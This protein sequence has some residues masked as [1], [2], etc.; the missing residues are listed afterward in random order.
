MG[1]PGGVRRLIETALPLERIGAAAVRESQGRVQPLHPW[2]SRKP[3]PAV[4]AVLLASLLADPGSGDRPALLER[5]AEAAEAAPGGEGIAAARRLL[6]G[7][8]PLP[9]VVDPFCGS[10]A[11]PAEAQRLG[12]PV[13]A[14]DLNPVAVLMTRALLEVPGRFAERRP[15]HPGAPFVAQGR[16]DG[17]IADILHYGQR[18]RAEAARRIGALYPTDAAGRPVIAW[19]WARTAPCPN[20]A[21]RQAMPLLHSFTLGAREGHEAWLVPGAGGWR[22]EGVPGVAPPAEGT[23]T[24]RTVRC[25]HCGQVTPLPV[26]R[27]R[28]REAG[29][30]LTLLCRVAQQ[31][32]R[33]GYTEAVPGEEAAALAA[34]S[35]WAPE[36]RLPEAALGFGTAN[37]GF[38]LHRDLYAPRQLAALTTFADAV[39][40]VREAVEADARRAGLPAGAALRDGGDGAVAHAEA[41]TLYLALALDRAAA[42]WCTFARWHRTRENIEHPFATPGLPMPWDFAE[43]NPFSE[44]TGNW[45]D[46]VEAVA[47]ALAAAPAAEGPVPPARCVQADAAEAPAVPGP[48]LVCTD[49]PYFDMVPFAD[50]SDLFYIWLRPTAGRIY[51]DLFRT[52]LTPKEGE[53]VADARRF[54]G[55][56]PARAH[57]LRGMT[58]AFQRLAAQAGPDHPLTIFYAFREDAAAGAPRGW[59]VVLE[60]LVAAGLQV[61]GTWPLRT[62]H[63]QRLRSRASN[64]LATSIV[65][66]C[67]PRPADAGSISRREFAAALRRQLPTALQ[68]L[69]DGGVAP[70]DLA[71][72]AIGPGM[73]IFTRHAAVQGDEGP[74]TMGAALALIGE[75]LAAHLAADTAELDAGTR[76]CLT[77][78]EW[79][80]FAAGAYG[81]AEV[82]AR[83]RDVS[84]EA[85][86]RDGA[87]VAEGGRVRLIRAGDYARRVGDRGRILWSALQL[88][89]AGLA[90]GGEEAA[91]EAMRACGA[92]EPDLRVLAHRLYAICEQHRE[93]ESAALYD[94][95]AEALPAVA[96]RARRATGQRLPGL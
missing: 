67:R 38:R 22:L 70:A 83:A 11:I 39:A 19:L 89:A 61:V 64:T 21:C 88:V 37:Y 27:E 91:A 85:L 63:P 30:G 66:V 40:A 34:T 59:E 87:L 49:P 55:T 5:V 71:Q 75:T 51:P 90:R 58:A 54:G 25:L 93:A 73:A 8:T 65:L 28:A 45:M 42:K 4:R 95:V 94:G 29:L 18:V 92:A 47:G 17:L 31:G 32:R 84:L 16:L 62:E 72:A 52:V 60:S 69:Q 53:L 78:A 9:T 81:E 33:R 14:S 46:A 15:V 50:T 43:A 48:V 36:T 41:V 12:L 6:A 10:G 86:A 35:A 96:Q 26:I 20:P 68:A 82:L 56:E 80:G 74:L 3:A 44:S 57:F 7:N 77:W 76:F 79:H 24:R 23:V 1:E 13:L 2:W